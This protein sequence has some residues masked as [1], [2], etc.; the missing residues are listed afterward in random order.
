MNRRQF[1]FGISTASGVSS[2]AW[3][4]FGAAQAALEV[5]YAGSMASLME[6]PVKRAV[7]AELKLDLQG[8]AQGASGLAQLIASG[9]IH[10]DVFISVTHSPVDT[11]TGAGKTSGATAIASTE[12]VIA[13]SPKSQFAPRFAREPWGGFCK[14]RVSVSAAQIRLRI[15]KGETLSS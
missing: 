4:S 10:P 6:G 12:M 9:A 7:A 11:V 5:A 15:P 13:Y 1:L 14:R 8:R 2:G 3:L